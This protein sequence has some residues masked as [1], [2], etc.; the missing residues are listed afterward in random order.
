MKNHLVGLS[1]V[2][3]TSLSANLSA[4]DVA[5]VAGEWSFTAT[6][7]ELWTEFVKMNPIST[8]DIKDGDKTKLL[9]LAREMLAANCWEFKKDGTFEMRRTISKKLLDDV[10]AVQDKFDQTPMNK[11]MVAQITSTPTDKPEVVFSGDWLQKGDKVSIRFKSP[12]DGVAPEM[13]QVTAEGITTEDG[14]KLARKK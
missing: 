2:V 1:L 7:S 13:L 8:K 6:D 5:N 12:D 14:R 9:D 10:K 3:L 4:A 11:A